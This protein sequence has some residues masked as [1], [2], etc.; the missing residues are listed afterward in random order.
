M[1]LDVGAEF[2]LLF[3]VA[4]RGG[5]RGVP[6]AR[7]QGRKGAGSMSIGT[8]DRLVAEPDARRAAVDGV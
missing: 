3:V 4:N 8:Y 7:T 5:G 6:R 2:V 1:R